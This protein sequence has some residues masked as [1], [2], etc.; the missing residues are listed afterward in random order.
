MGLDHALPGSKWSGL[1]GTLAK[2]VTPIRKTVGM[3]AFNITPSEQAA[4]K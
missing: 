4:T 1:P 2:K 3:K